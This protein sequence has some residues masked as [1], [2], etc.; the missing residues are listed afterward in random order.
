MINYLTTINETSRYQ[1]I[2]LMSNYLTTTSASTTYIS[3]SG[4]STISGFKTF[5]SPPVFNYNVL[6]N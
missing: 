2:N 6:I 1:P 3:N 5:S 4:N